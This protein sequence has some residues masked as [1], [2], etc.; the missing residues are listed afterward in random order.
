M[1]EIVEHSSLSHHTQLCGYFALGVGGNYVVIVQL[2]CG[3]YD[4]LWIKNYVLGIC[5]ML[6][7]FNKKV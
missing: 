5:S 6:F 4:S 3:G 1:Q 2:W 7:D